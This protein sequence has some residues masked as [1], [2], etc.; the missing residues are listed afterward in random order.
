MQSAG[1]KS[2]QDNPVTIEELIADFIN[3]FF[4]PPPE[5][6]FSVPLPRFTIP[7]LDW[8]LSSLLAITVDY[9][10]NLKCVEYNQGPVTRCSFQLQIDH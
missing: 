5:V 2:H 6:T 10:M 1:D 7:M 8:L 3:L 9:I 4:K